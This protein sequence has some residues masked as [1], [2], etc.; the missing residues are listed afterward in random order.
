MSYQVENLPF[1][2]ES[3]LETIAVLKK[4]AS[5]HRYLA[6]LKGGGSVHPEQDYSHQYAY[7]SGSER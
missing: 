4:T 2:N 6:E 7:A 3:V 5:A 1:P